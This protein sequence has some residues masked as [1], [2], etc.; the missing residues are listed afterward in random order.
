MIILDDITIILGV[1]A[2]VVAAMAPLINVFFRRIPRNSDLN[3]KSDLPA[4]SVVIISNGNAKALDENLSIFLTQ[5][6]EPGYEVIVVINETDTESE[7]VLKHYA[8]NPHLYKTFV[9]DSSRYMSPYKLAVTLGVKAAKNNWVVLTRANCHPFSDEW[10]KTMAVQCND[11]NNI[12]LGF[13]KYAE[14]ANSFYRFERLQTSLYLMREAMKG[15]AYRTNGRNI[16][17]RKDEFMRENGYRG[18]LKFIYGEFDFLVNKYAKDGM[19]GVVASPDGWMIEEAPSKTT[20][21]NKYM[22]YCETRKHLDRSFM[23]RFV[24]NMDQFALHVSYL[25]LFSIGIFGVLTDRWILFSTAIL[26]LLITMSMRIVFMKKAFNQFDEP[27]AIWKLLPFEIRIIWNHAG[28]WL[29]Y[30]GSDKTDFISHKI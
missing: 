13:T 5:D 28:N 8:N 25:L 26:S 23:H 30:I 18:N 21:H 4:I 16:A 7:D 19:T 2:L 11:S 3:A 24:F 29:R 10:L 1:L 22:Y 12:V 9:P 14:Q 17:F 20:W 27:I 6:Y 15:T